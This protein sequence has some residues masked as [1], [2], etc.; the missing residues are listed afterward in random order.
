VTPSTKVTVA[1]HDAQRTGPP[2]YALDVVRWLGANTD[3]DLT[4]LLVEGGPLEADFAATCPTVLVADPVA[5]R[6]ALEEADVVYVNTAASIQALARTGVRPRRVLSHV[7]EM[8]VALRHYLDPAD[9][10]LLMAATDRFLVGPDC[11]RR[12]LL[13][14][15]G[16]PEDRIAQVPYFV[17][18]HGPVDAGTGPARRAELGIPPEAVVVG[19][20]GTREWRKAPDLF[21]QVAWTLGRRDVGVPLHFVWLGSRIPSVEHWDETA[22]VALLGLEGRITF[23]ENQPD[24][25]PWMAAFDLFALTSREDTFPLVCLEAGSLGKPVVCFDTS[26]IP[27]M[28]AAADG[29]RVVPF[30]DLEAFADAVA[31]LATDEAGRSATGQRLQAHIERHHG[32]DTCVGRVA[33]EILGMVA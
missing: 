29:G 4:V 26:G 5:A 1:V 25:L 14:G 21:A 17:P 30:L 11:A 20:C 6:T 18:E 2:I 24:P 15:H 7:H 23:V 3:L 8:D 33:D 16:V 9:H 31:D 13:S 27:E 19:A 22:D 32:I 10:D 12:N 28:L